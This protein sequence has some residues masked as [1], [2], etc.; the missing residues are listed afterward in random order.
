LTD[1][2]LDS[3]AEIMRREGRPESDIETLGM[4]AAIGLQQF[5]GS[6]KPALAIW[7]AFRQE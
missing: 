3:F 6:P 2:N 4:F 5:N 1:F 7:D